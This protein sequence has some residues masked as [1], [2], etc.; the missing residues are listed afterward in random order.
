MS[1]LE[2]RYLGNLD[3]FVFEDITHAREEHM[4]VLG[5]RGGRLLTMAKAEV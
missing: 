2:R 3:V 1:G 5:A 4:N